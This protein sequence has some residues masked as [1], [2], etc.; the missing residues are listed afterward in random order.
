MRRLSI[1][2]V[3]VFLMG[4]SFLVFGASM[5][6]PQLSA[7]R[8]NLTGGV[9]N[10]LD[11]WAWRKSHT[12]FSAIGA[13]TGYQ[14][15]I[16]VVDGAGTDSK[17]TVYVNGKCQPD[18]GDV[19]FTDTA[20]NLLNYWMETV[21]YGQ[22]A[23]FWVQI[24]GDLTSQNQTI[25]TYYGN[26]TVANGITTSSGSN[27]FPT[28]F[29]DFNSYDTG[30]LDGQDSWTF[31]AGG[32]T[33]NQI[34]VETS[35]VYEGAKAVELTPS[36]TDGENCYR[37]YASEVTSAR[38][39][40][41]A[42]KTSTNTP[43]PQLRTC[44]TSSS[45][46][47]F[48]SIRF[49]ETGEICYNTGINWQNIAPYFAN[50]WCR[51]EGELIS[52]NHTG[53]WN[54]NNGAWTGWDRQ[55]STWTTIGMF[56]LDFDRRC[57]QEADLIFVT[58]LTNSGVE[59]A[60][61]P[62]GTEEAYASTSIKVDPSTVWASPGQ[63]FSINMQVLN[64]N[65]L[66][67]W[68]FSIS[69]NPA[70]LE[71]LNLTE[72]EFLK[73]G[74]STT[75]ILVKEINQTG[76]YLKEA[77]CSLMGSV[78]GVDGNGSLATI[79]FKANENITVGTSGLNIYFHDLVDSG[80]NSISCSTMNGVVEVGEDLSL[81]SAD[82]PYPDSPKY[83]NI[84]I[85]LN[86][87]IQETGTVGVGAFN[88]SFTAYWND[89]GMIEH[90]EKLLVGSLSANTNKTLNILYAPTHTGNYTFTFTADCDNDIV[91]FNETNNDLS[92]ALRAYVQGDINGDSQVN[93]RDL[94]LLSKA[95]WSTSADPNWNSNADMNYDGAVDYKDLFVLSRNYS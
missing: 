13:G 64:V 60:H 58:K 51:I 15:R 50:S 77:T 33:A 24:S 17:D 65:D 9:T 16:T 19:R 27:T 86:I 29:V 87:T 14:V 74:G 18:F 32:G 80:G 45:S 53:R 48:A 38:I 81:A 41:Y 30:N 94:F 88:V 71:F 1:G 72:G 12:L 67:L 66:Y 47:C 75:G 89:G 90:S 91:E 8:L 85:P 6:K 73:R 23:S 54:V 62:W 25:Y 36:A 34:K 93:Y 2:I 49:F 11:G 46:N 55:L 39:V 3:L 69:W 92:L 10:W 42:R 78:P 28:F 79:A 52:S 44:A 70:A 59:P 35:T 31:M 82:M 83:A 5:T 61:G 84:T 63:S 68:V 57:T 37:N 76:G 4:I 56:Q 95:Y 26:L 22:S 43:Y 21:S 40:A 20:D 7:A